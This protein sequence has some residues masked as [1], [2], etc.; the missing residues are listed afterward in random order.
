MPRGTIN[1]IQVDK[2][3]FMTVVH[4]CGSSIIKLG[5]CAT[6]DCTERTIRR[7]LNEGKMTPCFLDQIAR[8]LD[9]DSR[10]LSGELHRKAESYSNDMLAPL[11]EIIAK[12]NEEFIGEFTDADRVIVD[13]LYAKMRND[14]KVKRA[15]KTDDRHVYDRSIFPG[16]FDITAQQAYMESMDAYEQLFLDADK[17]KAI[18][19]ALADRLYRELHG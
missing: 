9:V 4:E 11:D 15:A 12:I 14:E 13:N 6:I 1:K 10:L 17:Y 8:H 2:T 3:V 19:R 16:I 5:A 7:S 18:Q